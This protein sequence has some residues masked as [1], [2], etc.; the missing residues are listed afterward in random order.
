LNAEKSLF[1]ASILFPHEDM[2]TSR[3]RN[4]YSKKPI[5]RTSITQKHGKTARQSVFLRVFIPFYFESVRAKIAGE[6]KDS[7]DEG[8]CICYFETT[9]ELVLL[10]L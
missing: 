6:L 9:E 8:C 3:R 7:T 5:F 10:D 2:D 1:L 4:L